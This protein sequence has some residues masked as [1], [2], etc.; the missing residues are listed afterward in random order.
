MKKSEKDPV[1]DTLQPEPFLRQ[2]IR[3]LERR[4]WIVWTPLALAFLTVYFHRVAP[5]VVTDQLMRDFGITLAARMG[6]LSSIY[7]FTYALV[8]VPAGILA[9]SRGPR[10]TVAFALAMSACGALFF[11]LSGGMTGLYAGRFLS[12]LGSGLI[13]VSIV[14]I[15]AEWFRERE[16]GT[17]SGLIVLMGSL[18]AILGATPLAFI[19]ENLGWRAAFFL[20]SGY[21]LFI[22]AICWFLMRDRPADTGLPPMAEVESFEGRPP[23]A[24]RR[25]DA[26]AAAGMAGILGNRFTWAPFYT[27]VA[28]YG[29]YMTFVGIWG[30]PFFTQV[31]GMTRIGAA[32]CMMAA[33]LGNMAGAP[34]IGYLSDRTGRRRSPYIWIVLLFLAAW[35]GLILS[36]GASPVPGWVPCFLCFALGLGVSGNSLTIACVKEVN[37]PRFTGIAAGIANSGS[38]VGPALL[39]P[40]FGWMLDRR[41]EGAM[42]HG[43]KLYSG[44]AYRAALWLCFFVVLSGAVSTFLIR[45]TNCRNISAE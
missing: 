45:E 11:G 16:F 37:D 31:F 23:R 12:S 1:K 44:G 26:G 6:A 20:I 34:V 35:G 33:T 4:R 38:F 9:D 21:T 32:N 19:V 3:R 27:S 18:G 40:A 28:I 30:I 42:E 39:Q 13:F 17:M 22:G 5:G 8:Q 24:P 7:F 15:H 36:V 10:R 43:V 41:W 29:V 14:K 25:N 2:E